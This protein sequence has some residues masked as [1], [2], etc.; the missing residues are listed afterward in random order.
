[1][2]SP[3]ARKRG[4]HRRS[5]ADDDVDVAAPDAVPLIVPFAVGQAAVL[6]GDPL[7]KRLAELQR[8][9]RRQRNLGHEQQD[10]ASSTTDVGCEPQVELGLAAAGDAV[11]ERG[12]KVAAVDERPQAR[13][14]RV[15]FGRED[16]RRTLGTADGH[17]PPET[18]RD[19]SAA[20]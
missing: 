10:P 1:M 4:E 20:A 11:Q 6:D 14:R 3:I 16:E 17:C 13:Q 8:D 15:L 9:S 5:R 7:A 18:G 12:L 19:R 2:T